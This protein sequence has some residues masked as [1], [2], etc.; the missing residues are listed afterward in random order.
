MRVVA[1]AD[2][3][4]FESDLGTL[5]EGD[6]FVHAGDLVR[7]GTTDELIGV[8]AWIRSQ[9]HPHKIVVAGNHDWCFLRERPLAL[10][11]LEG[12]TYLEDSS[13]E[14]DGVRF[15]GSPWQP[16]FG[17][18]AYNLPRGEPLAEKWALIPNDVHVLITHGPPHGI[19]DR[20]SMAGRAGC[21]ELRVAVR[22]KKPRAHL[23]GHIHQDGGGWS[24]DGTW[25]F[26]VT[27]WECERDATVFDV[28][29]DG[30]VTPVVIPARERR[31]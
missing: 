23:F 11:L 21:E 1:V 20:T 7:A 18:W 5:P 6:V 12:V 15:Y 3:H 31:R 4:T 17:G 2:T 8:A 9:P 19:G 27:T 16:E 30:T 24:E 29:P 14:I 10:K 25:F 22:Q 28:E 13:C 26:N